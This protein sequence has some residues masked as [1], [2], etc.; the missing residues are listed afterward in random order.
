MKKVKAARRSFLQYMGCGVMALAIPQPV[1]CAFIKLNQHYP[2]KHSSVDERFQEMRFTLTHGTRTM[3]L[4]GSGSFLWMQI[5]GKTSRNELISLVSERYGIPK[6]T[7]VSDVDN[8]LQHMRK[9]KF[10]A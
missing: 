8:F 1:Q 4:N 6:A 9:R 10:L 5:D 2:Q 7:A 3:K